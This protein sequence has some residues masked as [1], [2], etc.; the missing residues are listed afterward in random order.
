[1]AQT[2]NG[3]ILKNANGVQQEI[4]QPDPSIDSSQAFKLANVDNQ[5]PNVQTFYVVY[6]AENYGTEGS[7]TGSENFVPADPFS[8]SSTSIETPYIIQSAQGFDLGNPGL[9]MFQHN[10]S[11]G[12]A[13]EFR[14]NNPNITESFPTGE[15]DGASSFICTGGEWRL[16]AKTNYQGAYASV[17]SG[18]FGNLGQFGL[19]DR[20]KSIKF[21]KLEEAS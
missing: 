20:V 3:L 18:Q 21:I 12:Y 7:G 4:F 2:T 17:R 19:N 10:D 14:T 1:M 9:V 11:R 6:S 5:D 13:V 15:I 8:G 16:Y